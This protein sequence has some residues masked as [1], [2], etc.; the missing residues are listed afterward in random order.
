MAGDKAM[1][2]RAA[3]SV[4]ALAREDLREMEEGLG[5]SDSEGSILVG[6]VEAAELALLRLTAPDVA[7]IARK[8]E[9]LIESDWYETA[10]I[11]GL[12][13]KVLEDLKLLGD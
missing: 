12:L 9:I 3:L 5:L 13:E 1:A 10:D 2:W 6:A 8:V 11:R 7:A 4:V